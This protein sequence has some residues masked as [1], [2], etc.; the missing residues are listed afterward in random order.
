MEKTLAQQ[1]IEKGKLIA[2]EEMEKTLA[3]QWIDKGIE[4]GKLIAQA[5]TL[6]QVLSHRFS[7]TTEQQE[8]FTRNFAKIANADQLAQL[9]DHLLAAPNLAAFEQA[10]LACL[11]PAEQSASAR[12]TD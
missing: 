1:W 10:V 11:P 3:P 5:K 8:Q 9:V 4:K 2:Q 6:Q 12:Q 7:L